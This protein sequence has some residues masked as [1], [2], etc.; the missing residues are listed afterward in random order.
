MQ[1]W[2]EARWKRSDA[3]GIELLRFDSLISAEIESAVLLDN[4]PT[5][6]GFIGPR[7]HPGLS[8]AVGVGAFRFPNGRSRCGYIYALKDPISG[9][10][11]YVG[12]TEAPQNRLRGHTFPGDN[13]T[14]WEWVESLLCEGLMPI[15]VILEVCNARV[16]LCSREEAWIQY[17]SRHGWRLFNIEH[18]R[19]A[20]KNE[21]D[22]LALIP[23]AP[24]PKPRPRQV[25]TRPRRAPPE[26]QQ[27]AQPPITLHPQPQ[28]PPR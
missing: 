25:Q 9:H 8:V 3:R 18:N 15:M 28:F 14:K 10:I 4:M 21:S 27:H 1:K 6:R 2:R 24:R 23:F 11:H 5:D 26:S 19:P 13:L 16:S 20:R 12:Q 17:G 22:R 7:H